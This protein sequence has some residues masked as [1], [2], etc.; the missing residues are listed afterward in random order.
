MNVYLNDWSLGTKDMHLFDEWAKVRQF[1]DV[2]KR[3]QELGVSK[4]VVPDDYN[5]MMLCDFLYGDCYIV[6]SSLTHAPEENRKLS[7]AER[8]QL[9]C[10]QEMMSLTSHFKRASLEGV[11][12]GFK[13]EE[14]GRTSVLL[15]NAYENDWTCVSFTFA[16]KFAADVVSGQM[17]G[18][19]A[20][21]RF[22]EVKNMYDD[23]GTAKDILQK[24]VSVKACKDKNPLNTPIWNHEL[25]DTFLESVG[26]TRKQ[27][28]EN[29]ESKRALLRD[30]SETIALLNGWAKDNG[31]S[32][33]NH[34][35]IYRSIK[36]VRRANCYLSID[37]EKDDV[38]FELYNHR[39]KHQGEY[40]WTGRNTKGRDATGK[41]D[42]NV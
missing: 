35:P 39:G 23:G 40:D 14:D 31:V 22:V 9:L 33:K 36:F 25:V 34:R 26:M 3:L 7:A 42:I 30:H 32:S 6:V 27:I 41:H 29:H 38:H 13:L 19:R 16:P 20:N 17:Q 11:N 21:G 28:E 12:P 24:L 37:F 8:T 4:V 5:K 2:V 1:V 10:C 18:G 15:G